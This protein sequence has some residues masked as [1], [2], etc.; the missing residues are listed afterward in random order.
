MTV[1]SAPTTAPADDRRKKRAAVARFVLAGVAVLG[2]GAAATSAAWTDDAWFS[3]SATAATVE[4]EAS[5]NGTDWEPADTSATAVVVPAAQFA[6]MVPGQTRTVTLH[7][8]NISSVPL[9]LGAPVV[10]PSG[11]MFTGTGPATATVATPATPIAAGAA[12]T[13]TLTVTTPPLWDASYQNASGSVTIQFQGQT[14]A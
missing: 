5:L 13:V 2:I 10:T 11:S 6:N 14:T 8:R 12:T 7:L 4:L 9:A 1:H 3:A